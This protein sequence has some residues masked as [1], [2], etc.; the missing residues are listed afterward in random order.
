MDSERYWE[1]PLRVVARFSERLILLEQ[2]D[3]LPF[4]LKKWLGRLFW[5]Y[6]FLFLALML[7]N[8]RLAFAGSDFFRNAAWPLYVLWGLYAIQL[9]FLYL[10]SH[11]LQTLYLYLKR[12][13]VPPS[14]AIG[15]SAFTIIGVV[16]TAGF[17]FR[18]V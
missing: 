3:T 15:I 7:V 9:V 1:I 10:P 8:D 18:H 11:C 17:V 4:G 6:H 13:G 14:Q 5:S 16:A 12:K 2:L